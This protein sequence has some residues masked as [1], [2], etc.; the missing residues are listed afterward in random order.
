MRARTFTHVTIRHSSV[1]VVS[2]LRAERPRNRG[3]ISGWPER[4]IFWYRD[5]AVGHTWRHVGWL[6]ASFPRGRGMK[7]TTYLNVLPRLRIHGA[8]PPPLHLHLWR[9]AQYS[10]VA[11][12][13]YLATHISPL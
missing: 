1:M 12:D 5:W 9:V 7:L 10:T 6:P 13:L 2:M 4:E 11:G 3:L 8:V